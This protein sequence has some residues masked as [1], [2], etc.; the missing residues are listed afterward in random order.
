MYNYNSASLSLHF[1][2]TSKTSAHLGARKHPPCTAPLWK[3]PDPNAAAFPAAP[4]WHQLW[5]W[6]GINLER[7]HTFAPTSNIYPH[8]G[9][10]YH[11]FGTW[12][13]MKCYEYLWM[14]WI[15]YLHLPSMLGQA[16]GVTVASN[17]CVDLGGSWSHGWDLNGFT[18]HGFLNH[19]V[20]TSDLLYLTFKILQPSLMFLAQVLKSKVCPKKDTT[21]RR[22]TLETYPPGRACASADISLGRFRERPRCHV[23]KPLVGHCT[24]NTHIDIFEG[25]I[26]FHFHGGPKGESPS[27]SAPKSGEHLGITQIWDA[28]HTI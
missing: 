13:A 16:T 18:V 22:T 20:D 28:I 27:N 12:W 24:C 9:Q 19:K 2:E 8:L 15:S 10:Q 3:W 25:S 1:S 23:P 4:P 6:Y 5:R 17:S 11:A 7:S 26:W 14:L 21:H